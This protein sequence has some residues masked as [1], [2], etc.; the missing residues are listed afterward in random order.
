MGWLIGNGIRMESV[1]E[2][3][4]L[5]GIT[6]AGGLNWGVITCGKAIKAPV[7]VSV[8]MPAKKDEKMNMSRRFFRAFMSWLKFCC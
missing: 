2:S 1:C 4:A 6:G 8:A 5:A 7:T 3:G